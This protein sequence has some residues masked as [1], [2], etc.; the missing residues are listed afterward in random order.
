MILFEILN[1]EF[2]FTPPTFVHKTCI[3]LK[4]YFY[5]EIAFKLKH[6]NQNI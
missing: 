4:Y 6:H 3:N 5:L 2:Y 1:L